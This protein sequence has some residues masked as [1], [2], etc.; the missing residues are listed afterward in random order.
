F[1]THAMTFEEVIPAFE[2]W[3]KGAVL[4]GLRAAES[5][6]RYLGT[7]ARLKSLDVKDTLTS[8]LWFA[9]E[10]P[11]ELD[12]QGGFVRASACLTRR[13]VSDSEGAV[14]KSWIVQPY[15]QKRLRA[16]IDIQGR[17]RLEA[18]R[19]GY[20]PYETADIHNAVAYSVELAPRETHHIEIKIPFITFVDGDG[21]NLVADCDLAAKREEMRSYWQHLTDSGG[22]IEIPEPL[23]NSFVK[24]SLVHVALTGDKV[25]ET[26]D[27]MLPAGTYRYQVCANEACHQIRSL[28]YLGHHERARKY[29]MPYVRYQGSRRMLGRFKSQDGV[30]HGLKISDDVDYQTFNYNLDHGF[31]LFA[32][33]EHYLLTGDASWAQSIAENLIAACDFIT[34][35][36]KQTMT[37]AVDGSKPANYGLIPAGHL[38]DNPEWHHWFAVNSYCYRG[39]AAAAEVLDELGHPEASRIGCDARDY[40]TDLRQ[41]IASMMMGA[42]MVSL[43]DGTYIPFVPTRSGLRGRDVGWIRDALYGPLHAVECGVLEPNEDIATWILKD[44]EDNVFISRYRG[45]QVD[46][47]RYW[48]SQGGNTIQSG[49]LP[50]ALVYIKRNQPEHAIRCLYNSFAQ[51]IYEDVK[52]FTEHPVTAFGLGAGP[53]F[54]TPDECCWVNWLRNTLVTEVGREKLLLAPAAPRRWFSDG[55]KI[56]VHKMASYFGPVSFEIHSSVDSGE[57]RVHIDA[58]T[59]RMPAETSVT[60]RH[61]ERLTPRKVL[62][63]G[64]D[65]GSISGE[66]VTI[67]KASGQIEIVAFY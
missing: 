5:Y 12:V 34:R 6:D 36:R 11:E 60:L 27:Y 18:T 44:H 65:I 22:D 28:D 52:C 1:Y 32:L 37:L 17:G 51:N 19:C 61:P 20:A 48:F 15:S 7:F 25:V 47:D 55:Q 21:D 23:I 66:T 24:A 59:R 64:K 56:V 26:G 39:L 31:V 63:D 2:E 3:F 9:I 67:P 42:P 29:L 13:D 14:E 49:L 54:K 53:F 4:V 50:I 45:R 38:E 46:T 16:Y 8:C 58:P 10:E 41:S 30:L 35:E 40:K 62:V 57:I 33:C 43:S